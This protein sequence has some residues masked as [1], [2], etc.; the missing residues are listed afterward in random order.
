[1]SSCGGY[2]SRM[3]LRRSWGTLVAVAIGVAGC[4]SGQASTAAPRSH[5]DTTRNT[6]VEAPRE[7]SSTGGGGDMRGSGRGGEHRPEK[8]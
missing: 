1:M 4:G 6:R 3:K 2:A 7:P 5:D 8:H